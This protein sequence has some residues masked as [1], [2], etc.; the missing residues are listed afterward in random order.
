M[1]V[2]APSA[3][4]R[5]RGPARGGSPELIAVTAVA[6]VAAVWVGLQFALFGTDRFLG[7]DEAVYFSQ[8]APQVPALDFS[9]QRARGMVVVAAPVA[10]AGVTALRVYL[11]ALSGVALFAAFWPWARRLGAAAPVA[12]AIFAVTWGPL[13]FGSELYPNLLAALSAVAVTGWFAEHL[14]TGGLRPLVGVVVGVA[15]AAVLRPS[16][17]VWLALAL[18]VSMVVVYRTVR[19]APTAALAVGGIIG[20]TPWLVEAFVR[21]GGPIQRLRDAAGLSMG[22]DDRNNVAQYLNIVEGPVRAVVP[23]P[24][25]TPT[26]V[27]WLTAIAVVVA[28]G[29]AQHGRP[30][31]R[32]PT[33][34]AL[35]ASLGLLLPYLTVTGG[36]NV[37]YVL[38]AYALACVPAGV[39][40][41]VLWGARRGRRT[42][43]VALVVVLAVWAGWQGVLADRNEEDLATERQDYVELAGALEAR[44]GD[45]PCVFA[46]EFGYPSIHVASG[47]Q[48]ARLMLG[49]PGLVSENVTFDMDEFAALGWHVFALA[50]STPPPDSPL[51]DWPAEPISTATGEW[52]LYEHPR[53]GGA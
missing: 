24:T 2:V 47:C 43:R 27:V 9:A 16:D 52:M 8:V 37:R 18:L 22:G 42:L 40:L 4:V 39:G 10:W 51:T 23:D 11:I 38:P 15:A 19:V 41:V 7:W 32:A 13:V 12:A 35:I 44:A 48:G 1:H 46:S 17:S 31:W 26:A 53:S 50:R 29:V 25:V 33:L 21:F 30:A 5:R 6:A 20:S 36:I 14:H 49:E 3:G 34:T 28:L 45:R